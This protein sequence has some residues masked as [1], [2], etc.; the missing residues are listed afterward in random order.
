MDTLVREHYGRCWGYRQPHQKKMQLLA[1]GGA[2][3]Q[4]T[5]YGLPNVEP[6]EPTATP[7]EDTKA[8]LDEHFSPKHHDS[9]ERFLFWSMHPAEDESIEKFSLRVQQK[10]EKCY[11]G[12][13]EAESRQIAV[14][15]K[16]IQYSSEELRQKLLEKEQLTLDDAMKTVNAHQSVR[17]QA[18]KMSNNLTSRAPI[19]TL[20]NRMYDS[21]QKFGESSG[22][23]RGCRQCGYPSRRIGEPCPAAERKYLRCNRVGHFRSVCTTWFPSNNESNLNL[24]IPKGD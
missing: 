6:A 5:Y 12:K 23:Q 20:V 19:P 24:I 17:Y 4:S 8:K 22:S 16:I 21:N 10:A 2:E 14:L 15:D 1:M 7:Y 18:E 9:F 13:T 11:F 3:L